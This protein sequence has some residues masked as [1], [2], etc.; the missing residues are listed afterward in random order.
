LLLRGG[1]S[2]WVDLVTRHG[3]PCAP[4]NR[5]GDALSDEQV[6]A[7]GLV[8]VADDD[9]H[10][11]LRHVAGPIASLGARGR[12]PAPRLGEHTVEVLSEIGY[13]QE[14]IAMASGAE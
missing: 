4:V 10:S 9:T 7:R 5:L 12:Q 3:V 1:S 2:E 13:D 6:L 8:Q 14:A 11:A